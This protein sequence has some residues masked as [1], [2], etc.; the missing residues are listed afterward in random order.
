[1]FSY[2]FMQVS[3][4]TIQSTEQVREVVNFDEFIYLCILQMILFVVLL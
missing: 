2:Y 3:L 1:M 4:D